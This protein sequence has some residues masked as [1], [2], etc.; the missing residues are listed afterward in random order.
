MKEPFCIQ[1]RIAISDG[2]LVAF[3]FWFVL[4]VFWIISGAI[5]VELRRCTD[6]FSAQ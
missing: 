5:R 1:R 6:P 3:C 2:F 4:G